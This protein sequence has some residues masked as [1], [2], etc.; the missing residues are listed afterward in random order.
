VGRVNLPAP[1]NVRKGQSN[2]VSWRRSRLPSPL[3]AG[4]DGAARAAYFRDVVAAFRN[5]PVARSEIR[6]IAVAK[7]NRDGCINPFMELVFLLLQHGEYRLGWKELDFAFRESGS[8]ARFQGRPRWDRKRLSGRTLL[9]KA[10][11]ASSAGDFIML[12]R[13]VPW[14]ASRFRAPIIVE[15]PPPLVRLARGLPGVSDVWI[16]TTSETPPPFDVFDELFMLPGVLGPDQRSIPAPPYL[17]ADRVLVDRWREHIGGDAAGLRVG[18]VWGASVWAGGPRNV[19]LAALAPLSSVPGVRFF[20]LQK[21]VGPP[22]SSDWD[23]KIVGGPEDEPDP[24]GLEMTRLGPLLEDFAD[25]AAVI[26]L[27]DVVVTVD[28]SVAHLAGA[29]GRPVWLLLPHDPDWRWG[30]DDGRTPWYPTARLFRQ[31]QPDDWTAVVQRVA[32]ELHRLAPA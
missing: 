16:P 32:D 19:P 26:S 8:Y 23:R 2:R 7:C 31:Q 18:L 5:D 6:A 12:S 15:A 17:H 29:L 28:T 21:T 3:A 22:D 11:G 13:Y 30:L 9:V 10:T 20:G 25:T 24:P 1:C 27:L 4:A 14:L